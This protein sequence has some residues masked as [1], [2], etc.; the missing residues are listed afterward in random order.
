VFR[1]MALPNTLAGTRFGSN[2]CV[3][4]MIIARTTPKRAITAKMGRTSVFAD[5]LRVAS[6][7]AASAAIR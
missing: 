4:G 1:A 3:V 5:Q 7:P 6:A 2:A